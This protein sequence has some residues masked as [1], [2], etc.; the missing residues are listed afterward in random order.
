VA[1]SGTRAGDLVDLGPDRLHRA[2]RTADRPPHDAR[3][4]GGAE[5]HRDHQRPGESRRAVVGVVETARDP[6]R[7][8]VDVPDEEPPLP[9]APGQLDCDRT[10]PTG[11]PGEGA[12]QIR[13]SGQ[14]RP[15]GAD[16]LDL[17]VV[18]GQVAVQHRLRGP[19]AGLEGV[20]MLV[21]DLVQPLHQGVVVDQHEADAGHRQHTQDGQRCD[22]G[23]AEAEGAPHGRQE[24]G[25]AAGSHGCGIR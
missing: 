4:D 12:V 14:D 7:R 21:E 9:R 25:P 1:G 11:T 13:G 3:Q 10:G 8:A 23:H 17:D 18:G 19:E 16:Q 24:P 5:R 6:D 20:G 2:Q 15:V 22:D